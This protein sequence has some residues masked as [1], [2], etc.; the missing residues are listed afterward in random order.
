MK[1]GNGY[2]NGSSWR[3][4]GRGWAQNVRRREPMAV[5]GE[6][7]PWGVCCKHG[8]AG[9]CIAVHSESDQE[10]FA[11]EK[12]VRDRKQNAACA[13]C[14][15]GICRHAK[16]RGGCWRGLGPQ[17]SDYSSTDD[18]QEDENVAKRQ[19]MQR[20]KGGGNLRRGGLG[21]DN[22]KP[23]QVNASERWIPVFKGQEKV[24]EMA[25]EEE[26]DD[27]A[28]NGYYECLQGEWN[29]DDIVS[30]MEKY[31]TEAREV[32][33]SV[34]GL[35]KPDRS[36]SGCGEEE[37]E[38]TD[39]E[40]IETAI[41]EAEAQR[42]AVQQQALRTAVEWMRQDRLRREHQVVAGEGT[43]EKTTI[44][45]EKA[46]GEPLGEVQAAHAPGKGIAWGI[47]RNGENTQ[48]LREGLSRW[49]LVA[50]WKLQIQRHVLNFA[51]LDIP[52][53]SESWVET[54]EY[55]R[56]RGM[57]LSALREHAGRLE[58]TLPLMLYVQ[59]EVRT[60][61]LRCDKWRR[62]QHK[63]ELR[64]KQ[65]GFYAWW[66]D[67]CKLRLRRQ[68]MGKMAQDEDYRIAYLERYLMG[69]IVGLWRGIVQER[70]NA[71]QMRNAVYRALC[72]H[73]ALWFSTVAGRLGI[74]TRAKDKAQF[75]IQSLFMPWVEIRCPPDKYDEFVSVRA[76]HGVQSWRAAVAKWR[77]VPRL[78]C[79]SLKVK[80]LEVDEQHWEQQFLRQDEEEREYWEAMMARE[81]GG[82][83]LG[84]SDTHTRPPA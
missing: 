46:K 37:M 53:D 83:A 26:S 71:E 14:V 36:A 39:D 13:F 9:R 79:C 58:Q 19:E 70:K 81:G 54:G 43:Q 16:K 67:T 24:T 5:K 78:R 49:R 10:A 65:A 52:F 11:Q 55:D 23:R 33:G 29:G 72:N 7:C 2:E 42:M 76:M 12:A 25:I 50:D 74:W 82:P 41:E 48:A 8:L 56:E 6:P 27:D 35:K 69:L 84:S 51:A 62:Q 22:E 73:R 75:R 20:G 57:N 38:E 17:D 59:S 18:E 4:A 1:N 64:I 47:D 31:E 32:A 40:A 3:D 21:D 77:K 63:R 61:F 68:F 28:N 44:Q 45:Q 80:I 66:V 15:K 60:T 30:V 34:E